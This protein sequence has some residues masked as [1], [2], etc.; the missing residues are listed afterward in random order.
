MRKFP[1]NQKGI[2][3]L[4]QLL[5]ALPNSKLSIEILALRLDLRTWVK[6][7][8]DLTKDQLDFVNEMSNYLV[9]YAAIKSGNYLAQRI[10][11]NFTV[12]ECT[13]IPFKL[14]IAVKSAFL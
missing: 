9:D 10:P 8:F 14:N 11:V 13:C 6:N 7:K 2:E 12:L 4:Q 5:H 1:F 3:E